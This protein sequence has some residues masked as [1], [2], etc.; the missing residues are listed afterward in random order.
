MLNFVEAKLIFSLRQLNKRHSLRLY[1][2]V[3]VKSSVF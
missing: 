1:D 2:R 3:E